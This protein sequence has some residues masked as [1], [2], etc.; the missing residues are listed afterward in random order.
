MVEPPPPSESNAFARSL[1]KG[2][3]A[4]E[5]LRFVL[6][7]TLSLLLASLL[8]LALAL[9]C[10]LLVR[11]VRHHDW[12]ALCAAVAVVAMTVAMARGRRKKE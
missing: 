5:R 11:A 10:M 3:V 8:T 6:G 1:R 4:N 7:V 9:L 12:W 2:K